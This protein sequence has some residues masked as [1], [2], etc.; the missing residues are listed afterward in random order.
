MVSKKL[1]F[2]GTVLMYLFYTSITSTHH[3][4]RHYKGRLVF[5]KYNLTTL[6]LLSD[7]INTR[8]S[9]AGHCVFVSALSGRSD[10]ICDCTRY[11]FFCMRAFLASICSVPFCRARLRR[12]FVLFLLG[13]TEKVELFW[14]SLVVFCCFF[15][16]LL[17]D[18]I[19]KGGLAQCECIP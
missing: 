3:S 11:C 2:T 9:E 13:N 7:Q 5:H 6:T 19:L 4:G 12:D 10:V 1:T 17:A 18:N 16:P 14:P 15:P 8:Y